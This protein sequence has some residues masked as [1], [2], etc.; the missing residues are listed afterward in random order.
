MEPRMTP[1]EELANSISHG[2]GFVAAVSAT[3][4]LVVRAVR[5]GGAANIVASSV[6]GAAM[7]LLYLSSC[8]YHAAP[9]GPRKQLL[10][11]FDHAAIYLLIAGT[12]TPFTLGILRGR[13]GWT[14]FGIVWGAAVVGVAVKLGYG[15][16]YRRLSTL[17]YVLMGWLIV[18][19]IRP[20]LMNM[21]PQ[22]LIL[23]AAGGVAYMLGTFFYL[24]HRIPYGH[25]VWHLFVLAGTT[26][27]FFAV[28]DHAI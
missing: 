10:E 27:H 21:A 15:V 24:N 12:Y 3:P 25:F 13:W 23:L 4:I 16:R 7:M 26:C 17:M 6:F 1:R 28:L 18:I 22:G 2:L 11:R 5:T 14:L 9:P 20:L 19:P 8:V